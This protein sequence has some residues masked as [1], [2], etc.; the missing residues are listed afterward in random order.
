MKVLFLYGIKALYPFVNLIYDCCFVLWSLIRSFCGVMIIYVLNSWR[1]I[2][3]ILLSWKYIPSICESYCEDYSLN[4]LPLECIVIYSLC[5]NIRIWFRRKFEMGKDHTNVATIQVPL[6]IGDDKKNQTMVI[7]FMSMKEDVICYI[8]D[9]D[10]PYL[11][12]YVAKLVWN[13]KHNKKF[14]FDKQNAYNAHGGR[15]FSLQV[16][17]KVVVEKMIMHI[18][19]NALHVTYEGFI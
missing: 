13:Q 6:S 8:F 7:L 1:V 16:V 11:L 10:D 19:W 4:A 3:F 18:M 17:G 9:Q 15:T 2:M 5:W 12:D 14:I